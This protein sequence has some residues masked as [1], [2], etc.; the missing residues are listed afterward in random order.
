MNLHR[1]LFGHSEQSL[2][3]EMANIEINFYTINFQHQIFKV[4]PSFP[5]NIHTKTNTPQPNRS[6]SITKPSI[7]LQ[8]RND[9]THDSDPRV[10]GGR[11]PRRLPNSQ[12]EHL[13]DAN[14][15]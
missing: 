5:R 11:H 7:S 3:G 4:K 12:N 1:T 15:A 6:S 8:S 13:P 9:N 2:R 10:E 14:C